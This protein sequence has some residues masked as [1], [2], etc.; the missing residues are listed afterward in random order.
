MLPSFLHH[1]HSSLFFLIISPMG[2]LAL[3]DSVFLVPYLLVLLSSWWRFRSWMQ[4]AVH[5]HRLHFIFSILYGVIWRSRCNGGLSRIS[6]RIPNHHFPTWKIT[7]P[8]LSHCAA[9]IS[10]SRVCTTTDRSRQRPRDQLFILYDGVCIP[11]P[12]AHE[13]TYLL[14]SA[15]SILGCFLV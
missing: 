9:S 8:H 14:T 4:R 15:D 1:P 10:K 12:A 2:N 3:S 11:Y 7:T 13:T 6:M 5:L